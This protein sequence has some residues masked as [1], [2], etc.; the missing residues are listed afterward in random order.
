MTQVSWDRTDRATVSNAADFLPV[1]CIPDMPASEYPRHMAFLYRATMASLAVAS[2]ALHDAIS[3]P[4][5]RHVVAAVVAIR[6][7]VWSSM[8]V[9]PASNHAAAANGTMW[10]S[11]RS[12]AWVRK[13][14][15]G[16][17]AT[18]WRIALDA[19]PAADKITLE[20]M[21][22]L[23]SIAPL[24]LSMTASSQVVTGGGFAVPYIEGAISKCLHAR[25]NK[26]AYKCARL[27]TPLI[28]DAMKLGS[29]SRMP[30][31]AVRA[32]AIDPLLQ[33][34]AERRILTTA[35]ELAWSRKRERTA[36]ERPSVST[37]SLVPEKTTDEEVG[38][39]AGIRAALAASLGVEMDDDS[40][41]VATGLSNSAPGT[42]EPESEPGTVVP[43]RAAT[44]PPEMTDA[45]R[46]MFRTA[47][48]G[49]HENGVL[50]NT[51]QLDLEEEVSF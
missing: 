24:V 10:D 6:V 42:P 45:D 30:A 22:A 29:V 2:P 3:T 49:A 48:A 50:E 1:V 23:C 8:N 51:G 16:Q 13:S 31:A 47:L 35:R 19:T 34:C 27:S 17:L 43:S 39:W 28:W 32:W 40:I 44:P 21:L 37:A 5:A 18:A 9:L 41:S 14:G 36:L 25:L 33:I 38:A 20:V 7:G 15:A 11:K 4:C 12:T 26:P 46:A